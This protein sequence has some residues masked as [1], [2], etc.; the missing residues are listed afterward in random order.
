MRNRRKAP[1]GQAIVEY[2]LIAFELYIALGI[3][4]HH[5]GPALAVRDAGDIRALMLCIQI[6]LYEE[7]KYDNNPREPGCHLY[8]LL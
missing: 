4:Q 3:R 5:H 1:K 2:A 8:L 6:A 7:Q